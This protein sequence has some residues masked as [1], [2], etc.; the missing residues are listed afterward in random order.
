M[1]VRVLRPAGRRNPQVGAPLPASS[2]PAVPVQ[3]VSPSSIRVASRR[4]PFVGIVP[5]GISSTATA[6]TQAIVPTSGTVP[7]TATLTYVLN[8]TL[9]VNVTITPTA[10]NGSFS[11][12]TVTILAGQTTGTTTLSD[13]T[14]GVSTISSVNT[15][16]LTNPANITFTGL[17][18]VSPPILAYLTGVSEPLA[19]LASL[20][21]LGGA[22]GQ[23][24]RPIPATGAV[25]YT[26]AISPTSGTPPTTATLTFTLSATLATNITFTPTSL[27]ASFSPT[28]VTITAGSL[29]GTTTVTLDYV[30]VTTISSTN[31]GGLTNPSPVTWTGVGGGG[32]SG[33][34]S[35][36][37]ITRPFTDTW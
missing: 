25:T 11:P 13:S 22:N 16:G 36:V 3:V 8:G 30:G 21:L 7:A 23:I 9:A 26:M 37:N 1:P 35:L 27:T 12:T 33:A 20:N 14:V 29:T 15:G 17:A 19:S 6:Y 32:G 2:I 4:K 31:N 18:S 10:T 5:L 24:I 28:T 34:Q